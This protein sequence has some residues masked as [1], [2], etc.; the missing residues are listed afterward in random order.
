[1]DIFT[2]VTGIAITDPRIIP[3]V[4]YIEKIS[5]D[6]MYKLASNGATVIHPN[7]VELGREFKIPI[8]VL[9]TFENNSGTLISNYG[10]NKEKIIGIGIKK[11]DEDEAISI[12]FNPE[13]RDVIMVKLDEFISEERE[14]ILSIN[15]SEYK[16]TLLV[17]D[18]EKTYIVQKLYDLLIESQLR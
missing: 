1:V 10:N 7:A 8:R 15:H 6:D 5:Y 17:K 12:I 9:S 3:N 11:H 16:V 2:D 13:Y 4:K 14:K 18:E